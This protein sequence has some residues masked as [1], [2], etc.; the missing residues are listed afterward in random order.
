MVLQ[1][2]IQQYRTAGEALHI[3]RYIYGSYHS[4]Y[5]AVP[6]VKLGNNAL[7]VLDTPI[8]FQSSLNITRRLEVCTHNRGTLPKETGPIFCLSSLAGMRLRVEASA[9]S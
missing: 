2:F 1:I 7:V 6:Q 5:T 3:P 4:G 9:L 8:Y